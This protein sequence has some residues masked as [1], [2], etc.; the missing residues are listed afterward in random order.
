MVTDS[1]EETCN[2]L[3]TSRLQLPPKPPDLHPA[4]IDTGTTSNFFCISAPIKDV[5]L[6]ITPIHCQTPTG[7]TRTSTHVGQLDI[8]PYGLP[9]EATTIHLF[10]ALKDYSLILV[11]KFCDHGCQAIFT[12]KDVR[13]TKDGRTIL[14]GTRSANGLWIMHLTNHTAGY[15]PARTLP[16]VQAHVSAM[17]SHSIVDQVQ[18][19]HAALFSPVPS[20]LLKAIRNGHFAT[21]P[22][23]TAANVSKH[24]PKS[25][26]MAKGHLNQVR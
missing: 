4:I 16:P 21:W 12:A 10:P 24:L 26:A 1:S 6:A 13:I 15:Q 18:F 19:L 3:N 9:T 22:G 7:D 5:R 8:P 23:L 11:G 17:T 20:T 25:M 14:H 2:Y